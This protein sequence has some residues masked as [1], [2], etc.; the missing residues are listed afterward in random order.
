MEPA[1]ALAG[2]LQPF[3]QQLGTP[4]AAQQVAVTGTNLAEPISIAAPSPFE[5]SVDGGATWISHPDIAL[6]IPTDGGVS[7]NLHIRLNATA[8]GSYNGMVVFT[9]AGAVPKQLS[10]QGT[11]NTP[12]GEVI[13][14]QYW[15]LTANA[16]DDAA[17]RSAGVLA[18]SPTFE[19][20]FP[21]NGTQVPAIAAFSTQFG[22]AFGASSNGDG[23]WGTGIG[24]PGGTL[25]R[26]HYEQFTVT[27]KA[28]YVVTVDS[29]YAT[30]AFY[31]TSSNTRLAVVFSKDGFLNDSSDVFTIPGGFANPITLPNQTSGPTN[32]YPMAFAIPDGVVLQPGEVL[33]FRLYFSCGSTSAG[34]YAMLKNVYVQGRVADDGSLP[35]SLLELSGTHEGKFTKLQWKTRDEVNVSHFEI[36]RSANGRNFSPVGKTGAKNVAGEQRYAFID[37]QPMPAVYYRLKLVDKN[38]DFSYSNILLLRHSASG[39]GF[40]LYP[41]PATSNVIIHHDAAI[42]GAQI[43]IVNATGSTA[44]AKQV[45]AGTIQSVLDIG[46]LPAGAYIVMLSNNG[47]V[48]TVKLIKQ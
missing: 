24:G 19:K 5:I 43:R 38:G 39:G 22:Q 40:S 32:S 1:I 44:W 14:L 3:F 42:A 27:A 48:M 9:S 16:N 36:E 28:G 46:H 11:V 25:R 45:A 47:V 34:R 7:L 2:T 33:T 23:S 4:S 41:N 30:A 15:P 12:G 18:S 21:S 26:T 10:L 35:L 20:L 13:T 6:L 31:N 37:N 8:T 17:K 29:L